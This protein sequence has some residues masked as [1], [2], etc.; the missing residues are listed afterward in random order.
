MADF[1]AG[2]LAARVLELEPAAFWGIILAVAV[3][4]LAGFSFAFRFLRRA[5]I[6]Q[7]TP[8]S[9]IRSAA[10]GY[11][12]LE[13]RGE[14]MEGEPIVAP[15]TG[16]TCTW[17]RYKVD[18]REVRYSNGK[19]RE[20]WRTLDK[21]TSDSLFLLVDDTGKCIVDPEG[22]EV[23]TSTRDVWYGNSRRPDRGPVGGAS[24]LL[25]T[26]DYRYTE[27]RMLPA[28][29]LYALGLFKTVGGAGDLG[30]AR[31]EVNA[32]L[33]AWKQ[34]K[35]LMLER[36]DANADG[37]IDLTEWEG[38][39]KAAQA[40]VVK[41]RAERS[42][43]GGTSLLMKPADRRRPY[44]LSVLPQ[45]HL[46]KRFHWF[47]WGSLSAFFASGGVATWMLSVRF[48]L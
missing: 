29:P 2:S 34:D 20:T 17:Y 21:A 12:E 19:R 31:D 15:L 41:A 40:D 5:R 10:Q 30:N 44:L 3:A 18:K 9:K 47:A 35:K 8:T 23:T 13:G 26:G 46:A 1:A 32:V 14:L 45:T 48:A 28:E 38:A 36:F 27:E 6:I 4:A 16:Q 7:D 43:K 24:R 39:R 22:A 33:R 11:L 25:A 42:A 37:A